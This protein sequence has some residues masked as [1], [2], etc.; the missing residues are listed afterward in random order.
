MCPNR[1]SSA[2]M[3]SLNRPRFQA[4]APWRGDDPFF[5]HGNRHPFPGQ[6]HRSSQATLC[7]NNARSSFMEIGSVWQLRSVTRKSQRG[8]CHGRCGRAHQI[9]GR[10]RIIAAL[11]ILL[12][13]AFAQVERVGLLPHFVC[14]LGQRE[15]VRLVGI[16]ANGI[17][18]SGLIVSDVS[19]RRSGIACPRCG[20][21]GRS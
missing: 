8:G 4:L 14:F 3:R 15:T 9:A 20:S 7:S 10:H 13:F 11:L 19:K 16:D 21:M 6:F 5:M 2:P 12:N 1:F 17:D 18:I